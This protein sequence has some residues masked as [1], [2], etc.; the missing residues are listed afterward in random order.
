MEFLQLMVWSLCLMFKWLEALHHMW[1]YIFLSQLFFCIIFFS[2]SLFF[3]GLC[4]D[5]C[6][7]IYGNYHHFS[8]WASYYQFQL[9]YSTV[10]F[11]IFGYLRL[12]LWHPSLRAP[13]TLETNIHSYTF[14]LLFFLCIFIYLLLIISLGFAFVP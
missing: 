6:H 13:V 8:L 12:P 11:K 14:A 2:L 10:F 1:F 9:C 3:I 7:L 4:G 5:L